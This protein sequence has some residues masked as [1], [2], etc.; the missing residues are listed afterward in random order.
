MANFHQ[1]H[2]H[3]K[4]YMDLR[5]SIHNITAELSL[6]A[7]TLDEE[8]AQYWLDH[9]QR[10]RFVTLLFGGLLEALQQS[11]CKP[12]R[13]L[14]IGNSYQTMM[15]NRIWPELRID[16]LGFLAERYA[17]TGETTHHGYDLN[18]AYYP[19]R[20]L[21]I[22]ENK[23]Y[24][25]IFFLEVIEHL[26]TAPESILVFLASLLK[27]GGCIVIQTP[28]AASLIKRLRLLFGENPYEL[29][30][31][32]RKNP[33]HFREYTKREIEDLAKK[34]GFSVKD[35]QMID[36]FVENTLA[37]KACHVLSKVLPDTFKTGMTVVLKKQ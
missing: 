37:E 26:Y 13:V 19:Q 36:Y 24:D 12:E 16:T 8:S 9:E 2:A 14:D 15:V 5:N 28:N 20:W 22:E 35:L 10:F 25:I 21:T 6:Y 33:G 29:I 4:T 17:P 32:D 11:N 34:S 31:N 1:H 23:K 27:P 18:D 3:K 7:Q 30:R